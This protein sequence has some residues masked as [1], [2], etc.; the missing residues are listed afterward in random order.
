MRIKSFLLFFVRVASH[1]FNKMDVKSISSSASHK[2]SGGGVIERI[3]CIVRHKLMMCSCIFGMN[4][5]C[6]FS[7]LPH[8]SIIL[9]PLSSILKT[10][11]C[12]SRLSVSE[13]ID[14]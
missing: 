6:F 2:S 5:L 14:E 8:I 3:F 11:N 10:K 9:P 12:N 7:C 4:F 1:P 13:V